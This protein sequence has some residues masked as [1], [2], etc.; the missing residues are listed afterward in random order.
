MIIP[1]FFAVKRDDR[2]SVVMTVNGSSSCR[3]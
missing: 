3:F 2:L 1:S